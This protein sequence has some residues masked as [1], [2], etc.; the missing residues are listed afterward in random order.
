MLRAGH[1][2]AEALRGSECFVLVNGDAALAVEAGADGVH[3]PERLVEEQAEAARALSVFGCSAHSV[4]AVAR[5]AAAGADY[6]Q[7][8]T[9][10]EGFGGPRF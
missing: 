1:A 3:L 4:E 9:A 5:A 2:V 7:W 8:S 10:C 6:V